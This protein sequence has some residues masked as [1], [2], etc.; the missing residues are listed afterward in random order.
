M[1]RSYQTSVFRAQSTASTTAAATTVQKT[2][3]TRPITSLIAIT[4]ATHQ[5][6]ARSRFAQHRRVVRALF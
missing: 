4:T 1:S 2:A 3:V 5:H 6:H